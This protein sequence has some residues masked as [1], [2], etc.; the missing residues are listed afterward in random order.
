[1]TEPTTVTDAAPS[2]D[3]P[4]AS[5][6]A[7]ADAPIEDAP[8]ESPESS[9]PSELP[10]SSPSTQPDQ[11]A[12]PQP[13]A[14]WSA[15]QPAPAPWFLGR[16]GQTPP[17]GWPAGS[18]PPPQ[19]PPP[20]M[21]PNMPQGTPPYNA[22]QPPKPQAGPHAGQQPGEVPGQQP[23]QRQGP[24]GPPPGPPFGPPSGPRQPPR[25]PVKA[26][27]RPKRPP[28]SLKT[29]WAR[30]MALG[31]AT[32]TLM[33]ALYGYQAFPTWLIGAGVGLAMALTGLWLGVFA[34]RESMQQGQR[35]PE[36]VASIVWCVISS[37]ISLGIIV[38]SLLLYPQLHQFSQCMKSANT[39]SQQNAC[40]TQLKNQFPSIQGS[41][42]S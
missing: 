19:G 21:P 20:G 13:G 27:E 26:G 10:E 37:V 8:P 33:A 36:A 29:R 6:D 14:T 31:G 4:D 16:P 9:E 5:A 32:C 12:Q 11:P 35:A 22:G 39:I 24:P 38:L 18:P 34:Q 28:L 25:E 30:G 42:A 17:P 3:G 23:G 15:N 1:M 41:K 40:E 7:G 2:Q